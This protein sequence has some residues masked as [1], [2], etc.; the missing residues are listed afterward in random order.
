M[1]KAVKKIKEFD[2]NIITAL[3]TLPSPLKTFDK[4][5]VFFDIDK[6]NET[7][8]EHISNKKHYLHV[9]DIKKIPLILMNKESLKEDR[10]GKRFRC[11]IGKRGKISEKPKYLKIVTLIGKKNKESIYSIYLVKRI[12]NK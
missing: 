12:D 10:S 6:R 3:K 7:I 4:H 9:A 8:F 11:Y 1:I 2:Q 5:N